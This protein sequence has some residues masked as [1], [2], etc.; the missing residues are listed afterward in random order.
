MPAQP[1]TPAQL[2]DAARLRQLYEQWKQD[3]RAAGEAASQEAVAALLGFNSQSSVSQYVNGRIPLNVSAL[4][5]FADLLSVK[6]D[7]ISPDLANEIQRLAA[8]LPNAKQTIE[9]DPHADPNLAP[10][11]QVVFKISAGIA[12]FSVEF[13]D[14]DTEEPLFLPRGWLERRDLDPSKLYATR[15][16][17]SSMAPGIRDGDVIVV[18]T[19][20]TSREKDAIVAVNHEGELTVKRLKYEHRRWWLMSDNADQKHYPPVPCGDGTYLLGRVVHLHREI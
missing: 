6:P 13:T 19:S 17:G 3:R 5:K 16:N 20:N 7:D 2:A 1:L 4:L 12:G 15:V 11:R 10:I 8:V 14:E 18:D 9:I